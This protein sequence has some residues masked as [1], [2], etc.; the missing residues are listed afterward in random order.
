MKRPIDDPLS[1][2]WEQAEVLPDEKKIEAARIEELGKIADNATLFTETL[3]RKLHVGILDVIDELLRVALH[4]NHTA[5]KVTACR[6]VLA[7]A[8]ECGVLD[9]DPVKNFLNAVNDDAT[10]IGSLDNFDELR[11]E[12]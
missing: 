7:L 5:P 1:H 2:I 10:R 11:R 4:S 3:K 6:T 12:D 9:L 8:R